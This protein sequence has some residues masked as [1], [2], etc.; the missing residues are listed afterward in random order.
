MIGFQD[1]VKLFYKRYVDFQGRSARAEYWWVIL[2]QIIIYLI[3]VVLFAFMGGDLES[4]QA[5]GGANLI[6]II[7]L[8]FLLVNFIP[9]IALIIR[10]FHDQDKSGWFYLLNFIPYVGGLVIFVFMCLEGTRG[11]NR[12]GMDPLEQ[13]YSM[14]D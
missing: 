10:R 14:F 2:Y 5:S 9:G 11:Q 7:G 1:A 3:L 13:G 12:F 8:L 6:L 4:G